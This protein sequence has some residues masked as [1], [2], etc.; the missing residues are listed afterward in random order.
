[1][2]TAFTFKVLLTLTVQ[3]SEEVAIY[4]FVKSPL[5]IARPVST[6]FKIGLSTRQPAFYIT[7]APSYS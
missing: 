2:F 4:T 5:L 6:A 3:L 7:T 1:M